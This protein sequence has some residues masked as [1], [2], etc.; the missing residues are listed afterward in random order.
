MDVLENM[1]QGFNNKKNLLTQKTKDFLTVTDCQGRIGQLE[2]EIRAAYSN[3]GEIVYTREKN[4]ET[5]DYRQQ[6][7]RIVDKYEEIKR[8]QEQI[9]SV[10]AKRTC[11]ACGY[12]LAEASLFC[13]NCGTRVASE[14]PTAGAVQETRVCPNCGN[15]VSPDAQFCMNC[16][17]RIVEETT[18]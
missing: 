8:I 7:S 4:R 11:P 12:E 10:K 18:E 2:K 13:P 14:T 6:I 3:L 1:S 15:A 17:K 9:A 16:G 5:S